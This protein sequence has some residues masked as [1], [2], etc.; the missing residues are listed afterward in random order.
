MRDRQARRG[1]V[2]TA[3]RFLKLPSKTGARGNSVRIHRSTSS[4]KRRSLPQNGVK[5]HGYLDAFAFQTGSMNYPPPS[6]MAVRAHPGSRWCALALLC[7]TTVL[8]LSGPLRAQ[9]FVAEWSTPD[10]GRPGPTGMALDTIGGVT[11][12]YVVDEV[13]GRVIRFNAATG[14]RLGTW[15]ETGTGDGQFNRPFGIAVDPAT[16]DL[17]IA[18]RGNHRIQRVTRD[19]AFVMKWGGLGAGAGEFQAPIAVAAD[20][21][22]HVYV[23]DYGNHRVQKFRV[24]GAGAAAQVQHVATWGGQGAGHGQF[25]GPYGL[26]LDPAGNVWVADTHNHRLQK[27]DASGNFLAAIGAEGTGNG[28]FI[29][30]MWVTFEAGGAYYV[31]ETSTQPENPAAPDIQHQRIQKF[32]ADGA[33]LL[34]WGAYGES[35]GQFKLPLQLVVDATNHAYVSDYYNTRVQKFN[36]ASGGGGPPTGS[37]DARFINVSSRLRTAA[38]DTSRA[39]I[40]GFVIAGTAPKPMLIRAVGPG[41]VDFGVTGMLSNPK[42]RIHSGGQA[43]HENED[44]NNDAAVTAATERV[45]AFPLG[46]GSRDAAILV[47]LP[48]GIYSAEVVANGGAGVALVEVYDADRS[49]TSA[50]LINLST[51]GFVET[52]TGVLVAGFVVNGTQ[53]KRILV[54]GVGPALVDFG[55]TNVLPDATLRVHRGEALVAQNDDWSTPQGVAGGPA[56][57]TAAEIA[58]AAAGA[59]AFT[60]PEGGK[61]ASILVTLEPGVYSAVVS[62]ANG[63]T[64]AGLVEV[65]ELR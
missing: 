62:G 17:Y 30:P 25:N 13:H 23:S 49:Q 8:F 16:H 3:E 26:T 15:G 37:T 2:R 14:Q 22:G 39:F 34:K 31:T 42:L 11:Y 59:G 6:P 46:A 51:R 28:Q 12:L 50:Q 21:A 63:A 65:Y 52:G 47:T 19:G 53:P 60:L 61:D 9:S 44:W 57:A 24:Q 32:S 5:T 54:R 45:G 10:I 36:L 18:E 20:G 41:L 43:I 40:A 58:A 48:P 55:V 35:G 27:F 64:G 33:F 56:P 29:T 7:F 1:G 38:G 4:S